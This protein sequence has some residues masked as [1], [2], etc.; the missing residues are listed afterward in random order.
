MPFKTSSSIYSQ[1]LLDP[2]SVVRPRSKSPDLSRQTARRSQPSTTTS[3]P[4]LASLSS[5]HSRTGSSDQEKTA[6][7]FYSSYLDENPDHDLV[8]EKAAKLYPSRPQSRL[9]VEAQELRGKL[10]GRPTSAAEYQ[11][12]TRTKLLYLAGYFSLNLG[13]TIYNKAVLGGF[14]FPWLLTTIHT[15]CV[16]V[17]CYLLT[18]LG[19]FKLSKLGPK[20]NLILVSFSILF[21][22]NIAISNV[23]L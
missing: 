13:L 2:T 7:D 5:H 9:D 22:L 20:E 18:L 14:H 15:T 10:S 4:P 23:S 12:P 19:Q 17:G 16:S 6:R 21:T 8:S 1:H 3:A 11:I